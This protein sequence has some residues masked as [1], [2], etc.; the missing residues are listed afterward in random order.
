M[1]QFM[2][3]AKEILSGHQKLGTTVLQIKVFLNDI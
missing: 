1:K 3:K 2:S